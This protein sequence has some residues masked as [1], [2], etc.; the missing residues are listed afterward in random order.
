MS[1]TK[2]ENVQL[3]D[4]LEGKSGE[5]LQ[6]IIDASS[7]TEN[8]KEILK[9]TV[10]ND[11]GFEKELTSMAIKLLQQEEPNLDVPYIDQNF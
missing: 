7:L 2:K 6:H 11:P 8:Q 10:A 9:T 4:E 1:D 3:W 5:V